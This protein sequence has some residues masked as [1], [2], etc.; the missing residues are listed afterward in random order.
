MRS[1]ERRNQTIQPQEQTVLRSHRHGGWERGRPALLRDGSQRA[2]GLRVAWPLAMPEGR[3]RGLGPRAPRSTAQAGT[4]GRPQRQS[5]QQ[6]PPEDPGDLPGLLARQERQE[7]AEGCFRAH[8][9]GRTEPAIT[10]CPPGAAEGR[11]P[12]HTKKQGKLTVNLCCVW[13]S[14]W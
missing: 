10:T 4:E 7:E 13:M 3:P 5:A 12:K 2:R 14:F 8:R 1:K 11:S 9:Q 6:T